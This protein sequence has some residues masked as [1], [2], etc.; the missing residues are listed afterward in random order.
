MKKEMKEKFTAFATSLY[1]I[2]WVEKAATE[3]YKEF[4]EIFNDSI[5]NPDLHIK[6]D[7]D[8]FALIYYGAFEHAMNTIYDH[9]LEDKLHQLQLQMDEFCKL[10]AKIEKTLKNDGKE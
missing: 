3:G 5:P 6:P 4:L 9:V 10:T 8:R 7:N 1:N 2:E